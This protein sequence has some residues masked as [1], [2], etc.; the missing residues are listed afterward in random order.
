ML[1]K[2]FPKG[3]TENMP[4]EHLNETRESFPDEAIAKVELC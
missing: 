1:P 2:S 3:T 4:H